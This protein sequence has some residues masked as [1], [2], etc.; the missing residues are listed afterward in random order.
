MGG[1]RVTPAAI[2]E[3]AELLTKGEALS[4]LLGTRRTVGQGLVPC[5]ALYRDACRSSADERLS[6]ELLLTAED[7]E[8]LL[9]VLLSR[10][11][12]GLEDLGVADV[13]ANRSTS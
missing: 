10:V 13:T 6:L 12:D 4:R 11:E 8:F 9:N 7:R 5:L 1:V 2:K 3:A